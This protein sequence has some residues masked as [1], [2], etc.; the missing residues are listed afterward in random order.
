MAES[1]A[2]PVVGSPG[3]R[4]PGPPS[5]KEHRQTEHRRR[6][7][8]PSPRGQPRQRAQGI[9]DRLRDGSRG[10]FGFLR[11]ATRAT[12]TD[13][14]ERERLSARSYQWLT[15]SQRRRL[16]VLDA[17]AVV[18]RYPWLARAEAAR[19]AQQEVS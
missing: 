13:E 5:E 11:P 8:E 4:Q 3:E 16:E 12:E 1:R 2:H 7:N 6:A 18:A 17:R 9:H 15:A 14:E 19:H 10:V